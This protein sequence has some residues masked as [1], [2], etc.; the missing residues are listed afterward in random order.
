[1]NVAITY[2][3]VELLCEYNYIPYESP[4]YGD[5]GKMI[6]PGAEDDVVLEHVCIGEEDC[7]RLLEDQWS[8]ITD[9]VLAHV[10]RELV[11][12]AE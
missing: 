5:Y 2:R 12:A 1:M 9:A 4:E 7:T 8:D 6:Y 3:G 11:G 10:R